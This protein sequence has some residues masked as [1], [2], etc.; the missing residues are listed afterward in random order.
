MTER[1][2]LVRLSHHLSSTQ[3]PVCNP[4][5]RPISF[6][7]S[8]DSGRSLGLFS[9][10]ACLALGK[11][12]KRRKEFCFPFHR[13]LCSLHTLTVASCCRH[14]L[15]EPA[16]V[17]SPTVSPSRHF[18]AGLLNMSSRSCLSMRCISLLLLLAMAM[19]SPVDR[20]S[21]RQ[22]DDVAV[23]VGPIFNLGLIRRGAF[24]DLG[25]DV[26]SGLVRVGVNRDPL[27]GRGVFVDVGGQPV[28]SG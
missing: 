8:R 3:Q 17:A 14:S 21:R 13:Q 6:I 11:E 15:P 7:L 5:Q 22:A 19:G 9:T 27:A 28:F 24:R 12:G 20:R 1:V 16:A 26:L 25:L 23:G 10:F 2:T 18:P 4:I